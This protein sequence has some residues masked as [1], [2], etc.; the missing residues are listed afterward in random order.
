MFN[1]VTFINID[2]GSSGT[3]DSEDTESDESNTEN[4]PMPVFMPLQHPNR[5][6]SYDEEPPTAPEQ[7]PRSMIRT[8]VMY[9]RPSAAASRYGQ[10][11]SLQSLLG[12]FG[13]AMQQQ[14][15]AYP[16]RPYEPERE[17]SIPRMIAF[18]QPSSPYEYMRDEPSQ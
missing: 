12:L 10:V 7:Q 18:V 17:A 6:D 15:Q 4:I 16:Q 2:V 14:Q 13:S 11:E 9:G 8:T 1:F 3:D 5:M